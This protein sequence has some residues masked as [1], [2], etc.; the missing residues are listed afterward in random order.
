MT[1]SPPTEDLVAVAAE[2]RAWFGDNWDPALTLGEWW[3][4]LATSG[5]GRPHWPADRFGRGLSTEAAEVVNAERQRIGALGPPSG[6]ASNLTAPTLFTHGT[7]AQ[8]DRFLPGI[9]SGDHIWCQLFSEPAAGSDLAALRTRA[10]RD[11]DQW[12]VNGQKV[13]TS[14][15]QKARYGI[16]IARTDTTVPKHRGISYFVIDMHQPGVEVR[17]LREM[18]GRAM[19]NEVFLTD[20]VVENDNLVGDLNDGWRVANTTLNNERNGL[21]AIASRGGGRLDVH[22]QEL[23]IVI[24]DALAAAELAA[25]QARAAATPA[26]R[27]RGHHLLAVL[28]DQVGRRAEASQAASLASNIELGEVGRLSGLRIRSQAEAAKRTGARSGPSPLVSVQ[29]LAVSRSLHRLGRAL[30]SAEGARGM[31]AGP[32]ALIEDRAMETIGTAYMISIGGGTDQI[33]RNIV[34]ERILGLP[35]EPRLD[36][37]VPF[38]Q[39][40]GA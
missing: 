15:A 10:V 1:A 22:D 29:K 31:L 6:I 19:F 3:S 23:D 27:A 5:W 11:G 16:L 26:T 37:T 17:P 33:Q 25:E 21:G 38:D 8:L 35:A 24:A 9:V 13:W 34:G 36:K 14:G 39:L 28:L 4:R 7:A 18:T 32:D 2:A 40:P 30:L 20:A 12:I